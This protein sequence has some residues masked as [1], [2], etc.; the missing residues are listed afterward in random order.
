MQ[1]YLMV[2]VM[3][4]GTQP[5]ISTTWVDNAIQCIPRQEEMDKDKSK[6]L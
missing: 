3:E 2:E 6:Q 1:T 4:K 5:K